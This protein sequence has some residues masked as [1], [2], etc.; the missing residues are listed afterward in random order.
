M[1]VSYTKSRALLRVIDFTKGTT[2]NGNQ[3]LAYMDIGA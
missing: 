1:G 3:C 2:I